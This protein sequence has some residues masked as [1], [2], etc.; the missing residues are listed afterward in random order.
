MH[1][2]SIFAL[3]IRLSTREHLHSPVSFFLLLFIYVFIGSFS[4]R[5]SA[6]FLFIPLLP[7]RVTLMDRL[8]M[9]LRRQW[10]RFFLL[11]T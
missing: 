3:C 1:I 5:I 8:V 2:G 4:S 9:S 7:L 10:H 11:L 6:V